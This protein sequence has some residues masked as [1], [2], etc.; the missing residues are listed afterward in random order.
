MEDEIDE[1][2]GHP[3]HNG[4]VGQEDDGDLNYEVEVDD[5]ENSQGERDVQNL[6]V[7][8]VGRDNLGLSSLNQSGALEVRKRSRLSFPCMESTLMP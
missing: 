2:V 4:E 5:E 1:V 8:N 7:V 3:A 6:S